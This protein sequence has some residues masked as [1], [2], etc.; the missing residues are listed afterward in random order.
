MLLPDRRTIRLFKFAVFNCRLSP[1]LNEK[2]KRSKLLWGCGSCVNI[3]IKTCV[4]AGLNFNSLGIPSTLY[5]WYFFNV[6]I[7][8]DITATQPHMCFGPP[9]AAAWLL[10]SGHYNRRKFVFTFDCFVFA[11]FLLLRL[12]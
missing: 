5:K 2:K 8:A 12:K 11:T 9:L 3:K 7:L 1:Y 10:A 6:K 4:F